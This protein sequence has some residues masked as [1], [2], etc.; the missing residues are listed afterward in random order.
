MTDLFGLEQQTP[1]KN[2]RHARESSDV[3]EICSMTVVTYALCYANWHAMTFQNCMHPLEVTLRGYWLATGSR[4][5][6]VICTNCQ[7]YKGQTT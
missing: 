1:R 5:G 4:V 7:Q 3:P 2:D 6:L